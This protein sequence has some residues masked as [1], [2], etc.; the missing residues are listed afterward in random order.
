MNSIA[1]NANEPMIFV[2]GSSRWMRVS[3]LKYMLLNMV[4]QKALNRLLRPVAIQ[5]GVS[6][7]S[8]RDHE[9][10]SVVINGCLATDGQG[11]HRCSVAKVHVADDRKAVAPG[12]FQQ[13]VAELLSL[14]DGIT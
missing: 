12:S 3:R 14:L 7:S 13:N 8:F 5:R 6:H 10:F 2:R 1:D 11:K 9:T 4:N